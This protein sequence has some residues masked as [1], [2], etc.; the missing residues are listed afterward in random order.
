MGFG[1]TF[2]PEGILS[3]LGTTLFGVLT[4]DELLN[5]KNRRVQCGLI[6]SA[7]T[8]V[9]LTGLLVAHWMPRNK[10]IYT[11]SFALWSAGLSHILFAGLFWLI[12]LH[13]YRR[14]WTLP[15][16]FGTNAILAFCLS[17]VITSLLNLFEV[18]SEGNQPL[19]TVFD[20]Y[21]FSAWLPPRPA[22]LAWAVCIVLFNAAIIY[23]LYRKR[24]FIRL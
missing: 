20:A 9:W 13:R 17:Q 7:G 11:P 3:T 24:I 19:Y 22:S 4:G 8:V 6:A 2:D 15:L 10:Q 16:V 23:P 5:G 1:V 18:K 14:G 12:D 21:L